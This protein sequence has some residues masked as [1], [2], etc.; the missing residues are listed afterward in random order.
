MLGKGAWF[1]SQDLQSQTL[2]GDYRVD[3]A[4]MGCGR[5]QRSADPADAP[6]GPGIE[7]PR[8]YPRATTIAIKSG[9]TLSA[10]QYR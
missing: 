8:C 5:V 7:Q 1:T 2:F 9:D 10:G 4:V 6:Y 3:G